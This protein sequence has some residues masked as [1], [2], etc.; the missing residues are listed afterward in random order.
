MQRFNY[1]INSLRLSPE[2]LGGGPYTLLQ[3]YFPI[4]EG[5]GGGHLVEVKHSI[6][7]R[8]TGAQQI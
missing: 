5:A 1:R 4:R 8:L 6:C 7:A 2:W 3:S